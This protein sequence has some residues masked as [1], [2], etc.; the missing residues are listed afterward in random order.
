[1]DKTKR[2][3]LILGILAV[4]ALAVAGCGSGSDGGGDD[5]FT[6][7]D[8]GHVTSPDGRFVAFER[9][10]QITGKEAGEGSELWISSSDGT[11]RYLIEPSRVEVNSPVW[12]NDSRF[13]AWVDFGR[14][15][16]GAF[17]PG[18]RDDRIR[19]V[20]IATKAVTAVYEVDG[21]VRDILQI[22]EWREDGK[23]VFNANRG[24]GDPPTY[25]VH[26]NGGMAFHVSGPRL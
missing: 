26:Q 10:K 3:G 20:E 11:G 24:G 14:S 7:I 18:D 17:P 15:G 12:S 1:M 5:T 4:V 2:R 8:F 16:S 22:F 9:S 25:Y 19:K 21:D 23:I 13:V 6:P